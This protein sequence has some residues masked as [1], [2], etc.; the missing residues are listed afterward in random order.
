MHTLSCALSLSLT[1]DQFCYFFFCIRIVAIQMNSY[2]VS[3]MPAMFGKN[4]KSE[5][6]NCVWNKLQPNNHNR[7]THTST[8]RLRCKRQ[9]HSTL[10][11]TIFKVHEPFYLCCLRWFPFLHIVFFRAISFSSHTF[12]VFVLRFCV[13]VC[14]TDRKCKPDCLC[15][16]YQPSAH[17]WEERA[18]GWDTCIILTP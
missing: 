2:H 3:C 9:K 7:K 6:Q 13:C 4:E 15:A 1:V 11:H 12:E 8:H 18:Y 16:V 14:F 17:E 10:T 5:K